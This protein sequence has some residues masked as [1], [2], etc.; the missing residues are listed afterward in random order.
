M[1]KNYTTLMMML[2]G[3]MTL[4]TLTS[5]NWFDED[6]DIAYTLEGTWR[7]N[8]KIRSEYG[9]YTYYSTD[10]QI[11]FLKDPYRYSSGEGYW[12]DSYDDAPWEYV[13]NHITWTVNL[14]DIDIYF[15]EEGTHLTIRNYR[16]NDDR[17]TGTL[18]D[19]GQRVDFSLYHTSSP[20]WNSY[21]R[22]GYDSWYDNYY[23]R[24]RTTRGLS[25]DTTTVEKPKRCIGD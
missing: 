21:N 9:G 12:V 13:A 8:M 3:M 7:G 11:T 6:E 4:T 15:R 20:S 25:N 16:L 24:S 22:W 10:T 5:C 2:I 17:F 18:Y 1:K 14:G 19:N 23:Y